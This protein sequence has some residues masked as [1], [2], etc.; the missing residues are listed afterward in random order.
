MPQDYNLI[1]LDKLLPI[2]CR[3]D[4][5]RWLKWL[6]EASLQAIELNQS[7]KVIIEVGQNKVTAKQFAALVDTKH[8]R[9][10]PTMAKF[11]IEMLTC[12]LFPKDLIIEGQTVDAGLKTFAYDSKTKKTITPKSEPM[13]ALNILF[14]TESQKQLSEELDELLNAEFAQSPTKTAIS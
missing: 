12:P 3:D 13:T 9:I 14:E 4:T 2:K 8:G 6:H 1:N 7:S 11:L 10:C 5:L